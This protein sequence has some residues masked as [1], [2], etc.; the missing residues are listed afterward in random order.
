MMKLAKK[1]ILLPVLLITV[2]CIAPAPV[3][4][5]PADK[6]A[7]NMQI[8]YE[9]IKADKKLVV[10]ENMQLTESEAKGFWPV[11]ESYQKDLEAINKRT[12]AMIDSYANSW[13]SVSMD[14]KKAK[15]L[16]SD[17]LALQADELKQMQSYV[18]KLN[19]VLP[20]IKVARYLQIE[21]KIR[22]I[23]RYDL[24]EEIPLVP[25]K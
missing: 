7:D 2:F 16:T 10:A 24:A 19:K 18:S 6:P 13:N 4:S 22:A 25:E 1:M 17:F 5:A 15:K 21:N 11:Y 14:D 20:A 9:K 12:E 3:L 8:L 23:I